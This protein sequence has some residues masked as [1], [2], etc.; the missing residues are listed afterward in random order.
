MVASKNAI[1]DGDVIFL[2]KN[3]LQGFHNVLYVP[4]GNVLHCTGNGLLI[5][6]KPNKEFSLKLLLLWFWHM[7]IL[8]K[9]HV[10]L[11]GVNK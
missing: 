7:V 6:H 5:S 1:A 8:R 11:T 3:K 2:N 9:S 4:N 10:Y